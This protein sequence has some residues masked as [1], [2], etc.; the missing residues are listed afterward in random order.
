MAREGKNMF[1]EVVKDQKGTLIAA[2]AAGTLLIVIFHAPT[3][4][5]VTGCAFAIVYS[6]IRSWTRLSSRKSI[7]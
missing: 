7:R 4:A 2:T 6:M 3:P 1:V 5:V